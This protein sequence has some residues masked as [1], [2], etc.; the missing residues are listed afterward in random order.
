MAPH[1]GRL[2]HASSLPPLPPSPC[3][4]VFLIQTAYKA[5][6]LLGAILPLGLNGRWGAAPLLPTAVYTSYLLPLF[7][8]TPWAYLLGGAA[9]DGKKAV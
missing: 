3:S 2:P 8:C 4:P 7:A 9:R 5:A 6:F 1:P